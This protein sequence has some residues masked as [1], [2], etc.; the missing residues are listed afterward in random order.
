MPVDPAA[1]TGD[2]KKMLDG[3]HA[4]LGVTPNLIRTLGVAPAA[5]KAYLDFNHTLGSGVLDLRFREQVALAVAQTNG[6]EYCLAAHQA[7]GALAG[8]TVD[9]VRRSRELRSADPKRE[10]GLQFAH[11]VVTTRGRVSNALL[12]RVRDAGYTDGEIVEII[13]A[14]VLNIFTNYLNLVADT[15]VDF[16]PVEDV[17]P[18]EA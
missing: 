8:L 7:L 17:A 4:T 15:T 9:Q 14:V 12:A 18:A 13:A 10:A 11:A 6:C 1:A 16:P 5:L 2:L 3:V